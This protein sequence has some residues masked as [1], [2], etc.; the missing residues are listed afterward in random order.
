MMMRRLAGDE[1]VAARG[2]VKPFDDTEIGE[3]VERA[4]HRRPRDPEP[5]TAGFDKKLLGGEM[6]G[7]LRDQAGDDA[8][9]RRGP[10]SRPLQRVDDVRGVDHASRLALSRLSR[11]S[12]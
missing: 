4:E 7:R 3:D 2:Q 10:V 6:P 11:N 1:R 5:P 12:A 8:P 9:W